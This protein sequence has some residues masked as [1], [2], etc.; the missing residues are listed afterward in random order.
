M[1]RDARSV[2]LVVALTCVGLGCSGGSF[3]QDRA[4]DAEP[5]PPV[6]VRWAEHVSAD[7]RVTLE[8]KYQLGNGEPRNDRTWRYELWDTSSQNVLA[9][10]NDPLVEDTAGI[11]RATATLSPP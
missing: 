4:G 8:I 9:L 5:G 7:G 6:T 2:S 10:I 11:D 1:R 3:R